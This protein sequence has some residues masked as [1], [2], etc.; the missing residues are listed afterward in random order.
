MLHMYNQVM[1]VLVNAFLKKMVLAL[2]YS[3]NT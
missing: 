2:F 3:K 1:I